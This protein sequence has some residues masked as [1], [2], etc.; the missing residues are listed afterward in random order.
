MRPIVSLV[1]RVLRHMMKF[2]NHVQTVS[3]CLNWCTDE[4]WC[5]ALPKH[6]LCAKEFPQP[7]A[8][9]KTS[10]LQNYKLSKLKVSDRLIHENEAKQTCGKSSSPAIP[11]HSPSY[12]TLVSNVSS[13]LCRCRTGGEE[14]DF[15][16]SSVYKARQTF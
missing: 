1:L 8:A 6:G 7:S 11:Q 16:K 12:L 2:N 4:R 3:S 5:V 10:Y 14:K 13:C 15:V 9:S